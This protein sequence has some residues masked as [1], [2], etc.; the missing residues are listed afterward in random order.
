[1]QEGLSRGKITATVSLDVQGAFN[2]A[3]W[4]NVIK[5]LRESG[6]LRN[7]F[8]L[9]TKLLLQRKATLATNINIERVVSKGDPQGSC[10]GPGMW[11]IFYNS[12]L[13]LTF[14]SGT[15]IVPFVDDLLL[16]TRGKSVSGV[17]SIVNIELKNVSSWAKE[18]KVCFNEHKK[19]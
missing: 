16:L 13:N 15:K 6:C 11:N 4:Q 14:A 1:V 3:W 10:L 9:T 5:N 17:E 7:L 2:S 8:N 18:N 19:K 12:L